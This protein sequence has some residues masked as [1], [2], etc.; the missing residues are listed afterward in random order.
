VVEAR[1]PTREDK[2]DIFFYP[3]EERLVVFLSVWLRRNC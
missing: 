3:R 2:V 1:R